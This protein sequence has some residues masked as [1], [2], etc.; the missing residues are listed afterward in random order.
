MSSLWVL[1][2]AALELKIYLVLRNDFLNYFSKKV[3]IKSKKMV[4]M[5]MDMDKNEENIALKVLNDNLIM[6]TNKIYKLHLSNLPC[7]VSLL[8]FA[9]IVFGKFFVDGEFIK[10]N[11]NFIL[12]FIIVSFCSVT[13]FLY[14]F[15]YNCRLSLL[16]TI[17]A[18]DCES[19]INKY[20]SQNMHFSQN[21]LIYH[22]F[23]RVNYERNNFVSAK[24]I[25]GIVLF[26]ILIVGFI[27]VMIFGKL[28][29]L[30]H[31]YGQCDECLVVLCAIILSLNFSSD[32]FFSISLLKN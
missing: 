32:F 3:S 22:N 21:M 26:F 17:S 5:N 8:P 27:F 15:T 18:K 19:K 24:P 9:F 25:G 29:Y 11:P 20:L 31:I 16:L 10:Y 23:L 2:K 30:Q 28:F 7:L 4:I 12:L 14:I 13:L 1:S 6:Y